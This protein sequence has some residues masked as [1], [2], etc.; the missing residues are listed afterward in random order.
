[1]NKYIVCRFESLSMDTPRTH[2]HTQTF[3]FF[4]NPPQYC[5]NGIWDMYK[6][7]FMRKIRRLHHKLTCVKVTCLFISNTTTSNTR[8]II[9]LRIDLK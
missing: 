1:M 2:T 5:P 3:I 9:D 6:K 7:R 4:P 8:L